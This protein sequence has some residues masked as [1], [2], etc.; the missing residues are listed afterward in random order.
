MNLRGLLFGLLLFVVGVF[1]TGLVVRFAVHSFEEQEPY[2]AHADI[3][4]FLN[5]QRFDLSQ[6][7]YMEIAPCNA[8]HVHE[9]E[10]DLLHQVHL[11]DG[12]GNVVHVH[13]PSITYAQFFES[14]NMQLTPTSF[15]DDE[16]NN[17]SEDLTHSFHFYLN[18]EP[19]ADLPTRTI[20][21]LDRALISFDVRQVS[22]AQ[23]LEQMGQLTSDACFYSGKC[24]TRNLPSTE[25]CASHH[26][27]SPLLK[28]LDINL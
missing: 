8:S 1:G 26:E 5:G 16:G 18:G 27:A 4:L 28:L 10:E 7:K 24:T 15:T 20:Q 3:A 9:D 21:D 17:Y 23:T 6:S 25:T 14:L 11:H 2:H 13:A 22:A 19:T 12:N